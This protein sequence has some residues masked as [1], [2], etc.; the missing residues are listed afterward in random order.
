MRSIFIKL[1]K[2]SDV[3]EFVT[4]ASQ[5]SGDV[6]LTRG[7]QCVDAKSIMGVIAI[8]T[9]TGVTVEYPEYASDFASYLTKFQA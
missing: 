4:R 3:K 2:L 8:D 5:V 7:R 9:S 1:D 6:N